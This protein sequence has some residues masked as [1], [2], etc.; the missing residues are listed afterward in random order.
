MRNAKEYNLFIGKTKDGTYL[1]L[2]ESFSYD[3]DNKF[4]GLTGY[5]LEFHTEDE[6]RES[7]EDFLM[8]GDSYDYYIEYLKRETPQDVSYDDWCDMVR[9]EKETDYDDSF[10]NK[11]WVIDAIKYANEKEGEE[12][13]YT[14][15]ISCWRLFKDETIQVENFEYCIPENLKLLQ[16]LYAEYEK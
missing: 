9:D 2:E 12:Y 8:D 3:D 6:G 4:K 11:Q 5:E 10:C 13:Y 15:C 1:F 7:L 16:Q 14:N